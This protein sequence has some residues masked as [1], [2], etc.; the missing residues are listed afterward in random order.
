[1]DELAGKIHEMTTA[2]ENFGLAVG[3]A[4]GGPLVDTSTGL[5]ILLPRHFV[6]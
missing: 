6:D 1:M 5:P 4:I 2:M 3:N